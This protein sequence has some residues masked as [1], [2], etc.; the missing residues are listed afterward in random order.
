MRA[1]FIV[2]GTKD[3]DKIKLAFDNNPNIR[4]IITEGTKVNNRVK[5]EIENY[6]RDGDGVYILSDPDEAGDQLARM[7]QLFYPEVPRIEVDRNQC[8]YFTGKKLKAGI[9]YS[10]HSY[11]K[12]LLSPY[13]GLEYTEEL[14]PICWD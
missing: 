5:A 10:S 4:Y 14:P 12:K 2:E 13:I 3:K 11:L 6:Q 1:V 7:I 8:G 9:E